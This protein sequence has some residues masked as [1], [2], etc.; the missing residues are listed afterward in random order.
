MGLSAAVAGSV[1][2]IYGVWNM[3]N[4]P[5]MG[6][7]S[8][9]TRT[10]LGRR[11]PYVWFGAIPLGLSFFLL[12]TPVEQPAWMLA[13]YFLTILFF[14]DTL[15]SLLLICYN[16]LYVEVAPTVRD[17]IDLAM[18]R[19]IVATIALLASFILAP[20]MAEKLGYVWMGALMGLLIAGGYMISMIGVRERPVTTEETNESLLASFVVVMSSK[21]FR[22]FLGANI[23]KEYIWLSLAAMLPFWRKYAIGIHEPVEILG[24]TLS[25][26]DAEAIL[27]GLSIVAAIPCLLIWRPIV[28][29]L[30]YR[31]AWL[32]ASLAFIPGLAL[33]MIA[34]DF[35]S[36]LLGTL[37]TAPGLAGS[38]IMPYPMITEV[39]DFDASQQNGYR[40]DGVFFGMNAGIAKFSFPIQ[41]LLFAT[42]MPLSGYIEG[43]MV[44]PESAATG[45]RF[46]IGGST[47]VAALFSAFCLWRYPLG[48][49]YSPTAC[50]IAV[51]E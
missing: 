3:V 45:I 5:L 49:R 31:Y 22:Y 25:P 37:L 48:R 24:Q 47:I 29:R 15:Y 9:R 7:L 27:L 4:D 6:Q 42:V 28:H 8:D 14:F 34:T 41:G 46:L 23:A 18:V 10:R 26:G 39:I 50:E 16:S 12:W 13:A 40:R 33:M 44:Q 11:V 36:G 35:Y 51:H 1:W 20:V 43:Q 38:M 30:G 2:A 32:I 19:E 21:P 17:R